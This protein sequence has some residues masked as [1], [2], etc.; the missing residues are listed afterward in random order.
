MSAV[1][2]RLAPAV[3]PAEAWADAPF[4]RLGMALDRAAL[5]G[6]RLA[7][8]AA[9]EPGPE[10]WERCARS[11][12][13]YVTPDL[14]AD[15]RRFFGFLDSPPVPVHTTLRVRRRVP[16]GVA[17]AR[18]FV[19][20]YAPY[21]CGGG[22]RSCVENDTVCIEHWMHRGTPPRATV[23]LLHGFSMGQAWVDAHVLMAAQ[24]FALGVD[25][26]L[27]TL[28]FHGPRAPSG[29]RY[30]GE[31]F[32][33]WDIGCLNE[34]VRQSIHDVCLVKRWLVE[35]TGAAVG[36]MGLSL[37][38]YV[39]AVAAALCPDLAFV[40]PLA[41]PVCLVDL[42]VRL[43]ALGEAGGLPLP[44]S[45]D[46]LRRAYR[47][48]C[49]LTYPLAIAPERA[50]IVAGRGDQVVPPEH[51]YALW[52]HWSEPPIHWFSGGHTAPFRR[53]RIMA[54]IAEHLRGLGL[55]A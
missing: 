22:W 52:R 32:A 45:L 55:A 46:D 42:P 37:G 17:V 3:L 43:L 26:A 29:S 50:L 23:I 54:R 24:W 38:G 10:L 31:L 34:S 2:E 9:L 25:V 1:A 30:S 36:L 51:G 47:P 49:P 13:P 6:M 7:F 27:L 4:T 5:R 21:H 40:V 19:T 11:A 28:P 12:A 41:A 53:D 18:R 20:R 35:R 16:G 48:H 8:T 33:S 15:P 44:L 14:D 39:S